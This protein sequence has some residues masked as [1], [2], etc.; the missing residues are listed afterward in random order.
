MATVE[1][2]VPDI[3]DFK[4]I[5][6]IEVFFKAGDTIKKDDSSVTLESDKATMEVPASHSGTVKEMRVKPGDKVSQGT[7]LLVLET[8]ASAAPATP[9]RRCMSVRLAATVT[10]ER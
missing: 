3:G 5:P 1:V 4:D 6:V 9:S 2:K 8:A 7:V 10:S